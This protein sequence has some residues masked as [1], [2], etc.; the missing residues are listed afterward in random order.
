V[1]K[2][3]ERVHRRQKSSIDECLESAKYWTAVLP[4]YAN[5]MQA[6]ADRWAVTS[7]VLSAVAGLSVWATL[8]QSA[9]WWAQI[10]VAVVSLLSAI[11]ALVPRVKNFGEMAGHARQ[12]SSAYGR[13]EG[14][15]VDAHEWKRNRNEQVLQKVV[16][17]FDNTKSSKD[18]NLRDLPQRSPRTGYKP[19]ESFPA[20][21]YY[22][23][24]KQD[25]D[26]RHRYRRIRLPWWPKPPNGPKPDSVC[27]INAG[28]QDADVELDFYFTDR[29]PAGP[30]RQRLNDL[31]DP[32]PL[33]VGVDY[34]V[35][36][37]SSLPI[38]VQHTRL[39]SRQSENALMTTIAFPAD[40]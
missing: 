31:R 21:T 37:R 28:Q 22:R 11:A 14:Q 19:D 34:S 15:L 24:R 2:S 16:E 39:D 30:Y 5:D 4:K 32:K 36:V 12:L 40:G 18:T 10:L 6:R 13:V 25:R 20:D 35:V 3:S 1:P 33:P 17:D 7:G 8:L 23:A 29:D 26:E 27:M 38:V 9:W